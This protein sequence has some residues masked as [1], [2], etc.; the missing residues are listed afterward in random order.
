MWCT[1]MAA[2]RC[3]RHLRTDAGIAMG[4]AGRAARHRPCRACRPCRIFRMITWCWCC[5]AM[6]RCCARKPCASCVQL[7]ADKQLALLTV[8]LADPAGYGR[9]VRDARGKREGHRR[10]EGCHARAADDC[11]RAT[12]ACWPCRRSCCASGWRR[13]RTDNAQGEYLP[14]RCHRHGGEGPHCAWPPLVAANESEV[15]GVNDKLQLAQL[16]A[17]LRHA[18]RDRT[19]CAPASTLADPARFDLRGELELGRD[20]FIDVNVVFEGKRGAGRSRAH[21]AEL[22]A[23]RCMTVGAG[24][25][26]CGRIACWSGPRSGRGLQHR[27]VRAAASGHAAGR[28]RAHRQFRRGEEQQ[29]RRRLEGQSPDISGRCHGGRERQRGRRHHHLQLRWREQVAHRHRGWRVHRLGQHAGGAGDHRRAG[30][31]RRRFHH[32]RGCAGRAS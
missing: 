24:H 19:A 29:H 3:A 25:A 22:R 10:T 8:K 5:M 2:S 12:P 7:A 20:V 18:R 11:A 32:H 14:H 21:R 23:A 4:T 6:C 15:L 27:S 30:H 31:H 1:A 13:L 17:A 16:E 26:R 28:W 9:V